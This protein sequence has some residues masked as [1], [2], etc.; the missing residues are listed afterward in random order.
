M[1]SMESQGFLS[2]LFDF[3]FTRFITTRWIKLI[4]LIGIALATLQLVA[5][6]L[7][8]F[9]MLFTMEGASKLMG[10]VFIVVA[11]V[12]YTV[13]VIA[14]R[15]GLELVVVIFRIEEHARRLAPP[16]SPQ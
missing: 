5:Y 3:S 16:V 4:F 14:L 7:W 10:L 13:E 6:V 2:D 11:V 15:I 1:E 12:I 9:T 8:A